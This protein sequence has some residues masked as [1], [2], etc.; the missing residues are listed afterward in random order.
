MRK[1]LADIHRIN[2]RQYMRGD[3]GATVEMVDLENAIESADLTEKQ[4]EAVRLVYF[5][6]Y[7]QAE[8]AR[9]MGVTQAAVSQFIS[10]A[11]RKIAEHY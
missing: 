1:L 7:E 3:Y 6:D 5:E 4:A 9:K 2:E 8:A 10:A 11:I